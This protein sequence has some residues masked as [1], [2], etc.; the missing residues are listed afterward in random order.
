MRK[1]L[2]KIKENAASKR[3][4]GIVGVWD[5]SSHVST[6]LSIPKNVEIIEI[7]S[8]WQ[9]IPAIR[10]ENNTPHIYQVL[11][12]TTPKRCEND[13]NGKRRKKSA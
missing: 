9:V 6:I 5:S 10:W 3:Q 8:E 13:V 12:K 1:K 4:N 11:R 2:N 7:P